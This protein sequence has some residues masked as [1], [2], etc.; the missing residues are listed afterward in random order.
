MEKLKCRRKGAKRFDDFM[1]N[2]SEEQKQ[3]IK[4]LDTSFNQL[5]SLGSFK[6]F[7][8]LTSLSLSHNKIKTLPKN[9]FLEL[10]KLEKLDLSYNLIVR[11]PENISSLEL[12]ELRLQGNMI[13]ELSDSIG[14]CKNLERL[15]IGD[16]LSGNPLADLP[17]SLNE[18]LCLKELYLAHCS[19]AAFPEVSLHLGNLKILDFSSNYIK[20]LPVDLSSMKSLRDLDMSRNEIE[21]IPVDF[22]L[23]NTL[24]SLNLSS[25]HIK[26][27]PIG[28]YL[29]LTN[30]ANNDCFY[31]LIETITIES[32]MEKKLRLQEISMN[33]LIN[34]DFINQIPKHIR[35]N[36][37]LRDESDGL[38]LCE[39]CPL[40]FIYGRETL[41]QPGIVN[42]HFNVPVRSSVCSMNC[43]LS[44]ESKGN[45]VKLDESDLCDL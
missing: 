45:Y 12:K 39:N 42:G 16:G 23:P 35:S 14:A 27:V 10:P 24:E 41:V 8:S 4:I 31:E 7:V 13:N 5:E 37:P 1:Q 30:L 15:L 34:C 6:I 43:A 29:N 21:E 2:L 17:S 32:R 9:F 18:L 28:P 36:F 11:L 20:G 40:R 44:I 33:A 19:L 25:N 22:K 3:S 26:V 38:R